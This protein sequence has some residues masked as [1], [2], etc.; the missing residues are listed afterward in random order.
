MRVVSRGWNLD[1]TWKKRAIMRWR[2]VGEGKSSTK[3]R[4]KISRELNVH[5]WRKHLH[6]S[7]ESVSS[8]LT[9]RNITKEDSPVDILCVLM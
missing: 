8:P 2:A 9:Q 1:G 6:V 5:Q 7:G 4:K 3:L